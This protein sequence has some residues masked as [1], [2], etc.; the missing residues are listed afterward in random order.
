MIDN[1]TNTNEQLSTEEKEKMSCKEFYQYLLEKYPADEILLE[2]EN[3]ENLKFIRGYETFD[4][5]EKV[6]SI[7][8]ILEATP[9]EIQNCIFSN[10]KIKAGFIIDFEKKQFRFSTEEGFERRG[11]ARTIY[12]N[13]SQILEKFMLMNLQYKWEKIQMLVFH[14][15]KK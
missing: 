14:L 2:E 1:N 15:W 11:Y 10:K 5:Y 7:T 13:S 3:G 4:F 6:E 9:E 12:R 8:F